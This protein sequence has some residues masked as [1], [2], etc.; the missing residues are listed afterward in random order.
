MQAG[1]TSR[2]LT[3]R[4]IFLAEVLLLLVWM[5][6]LRALLGRSAWRVTGR[7][8]LMTEAPAPLAALARSTRDPSGSSSGSRTR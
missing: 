1:L 4:D 5:A 8:Q 2:R 7:Q 3:W 6:R